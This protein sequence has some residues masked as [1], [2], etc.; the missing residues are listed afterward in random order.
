MPAIVEYPHVV[1]EA[2]DEFSD[3][4]SYEPQRRH[5]AEYLTG[6][7]VAANKTVTGINS[8]F[9]ETTDQS[10]LNRFLT[11]VAWDE[12]TLNERRLELLQRDP[13]TRY[14]DHGV[15][16]IDDTLIDHD[17]K[18]I[19][20]VGWFWDHAEERNKIAHDYLFVNY[21]SPAAN[22]TR[23]NSAVSKSAINAKRRARLSWT[24]RNCF[25]S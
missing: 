6:L 11:E 23:W 24:I 10:C 9:A 14:S 22:T 19:K 12:Q 25:A 21:V 4:F 5:F 18:F 7:M 2:M 1:R 16:A 17:G 15:I 20:D 3:L 8:E 13:A